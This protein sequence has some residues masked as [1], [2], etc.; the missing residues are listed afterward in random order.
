[1]EKYIVKLIEDNKKDLI[2]GASEYFHCSYRQ[3]KR[4]GGPSVYFHKRC[5]KECED[6]FLS[7]RHIELIYATL[8]AWGMHRMG[9]GGAKLA[10][11]RDFYGSVKRAEDK[12]WALHSSKK[13]MTDLDE[14]EYSELIEDMRQAYEELEVSASSSSI[15]A[16][17]KALFHLLPNL[18]PPIDRQYTVRFFTREKNNWLN[19][20]GSFRSIN[21]PTKKSEQFDLFHRLCREIKSMSDDLSG[22]LEKERADHG[23]PAPK[24]IDNAIVNYVRIESGRADSACPEHASR[25]P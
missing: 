12:L 21:L 6:S 8:T 24:A 19:Q 4:F 15:V 10:N 5:L 3:F 7:K 25:Q 2:A 14:A 1:M 23:V 16:N 17:S 11:W 18:I 9:S 20:R 22:H 13:R